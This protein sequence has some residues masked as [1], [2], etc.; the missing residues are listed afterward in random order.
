[1]TRCSVKRAFD[2]LHELND[3]INDAEFWRFR[4]NEAISVLETLAH[5]EYDSRPH[6]KTVTVAP[7][8][9]ALLPERGL[10]HGLLVGRRLPR[11]IDRL[12]AAAKK[13]GLGWL[14]RTQPCESNFYP[15]RISLVAETFDDMATFAN[16][17]ALGFTKIPA[18]WSILRFA[19]TLDDYSNSLTPEDMSGL[20]W[21][22]EDF[23]PKALTFRKF[24]R[25]DTT[26][27]S[28]YIHPTR[29]TTEYVLRQ[30]GVATRVHPAWGR[31]A[32][33]HAMAC[34]VLTYDLQASV[35]AVPI[36]TP[37]P[38]LLARSLCLCS[39]LVPLEMDGMDW[40]V[41]CDK[42][43]I[44]QRVPLSVAQIV[45]AKLKQRLT[46]RNFYDAHPRRQTRG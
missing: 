39:G 28:K 4:R 1:M 25:Q 9:I 34:D 3:E 20:N 18:A 23:D 11:E 29:R 38:K 46:L 17:H 36:T 44:Y 14:V 32:L 10:P 27:L 41:S 13:S 30:A 22:R 16:A 21:D 5:V 42:A 24:L 33:M 6:Q 45:A 15:V 26:V 19:G 12:A 43:K 35:L 37:L 40:P 7:S 31:F 8:A 2:S